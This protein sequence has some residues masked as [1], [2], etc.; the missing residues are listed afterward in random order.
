MDKTVWIGTG[1]QEEE[2]DFT[3][4]IYGDDMENRQVIFPRQDSE[5]IDRIRIKD[6]PIFLLST[7]SGAAETSGKAAFTSALAHYTT[8]LNEKGLLKPNVAKYLSD[9]QKEAQGTLNQGQLD[10]VVGR[11]KDICREL[12]FL[13]EVK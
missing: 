13:K 2:K 3:N 7:L 8:F 9:L 6:I 10:D 1:P 5:G 12:R 4:T 11:V